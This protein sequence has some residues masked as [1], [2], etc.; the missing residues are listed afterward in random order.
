MMHE[1]DSAVMALGKPAQRRQYNHKAQGTPRL[2]SVNLLLVS[3]IQWS[4]IIEQTLAASTRL[5]DQRE[6]IK[7]SWP[8]AALRKERNIRLKALQT[9]HEQGTS[10]QPTRTMRHL[11]PNSA[12]WTSIP[13]DQI[14]NNATIILTGLVSSQQK[15]LVRGELAQDEDR[16]PGCECI[17]APE[18]DTT[19]TLVHRITTCPNYDTSGIPDLSKIKAA[20]LGT[21][22]SISKVEAL[23]QLAKLAIKTTNQSLIQEIK[24]KKKAT[25]FTF[26]ES[27]MM[28]TLSLERW[29]QKDLH[30][31]DKGRLQEEPLYQLN[32]PDLNTK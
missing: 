23:R 5:G 14:P 1:S 32:E 2:Q 24:N 29:L 9:N 12:A 16:Y 3:K 30:L 10:K 17:R 26:L 19:S 25:Y 18:Q 4:K 28:Q 21:D 13:L 8:N 31:V 27:G 11:C 15:I 22:R 20:I 6:V 7:Y